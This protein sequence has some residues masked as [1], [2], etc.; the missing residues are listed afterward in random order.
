M[1]GTFGMKEGLLGYDLAQSVGEPLFK[2]FKES[3]VEAIVTESSVCRLH[4]MQGTGL[5]VFHPLEV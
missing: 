3:G 1:G 2:L 4:L 5:P